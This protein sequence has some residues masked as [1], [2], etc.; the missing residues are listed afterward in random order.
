MTYRNVYTEQLLSLSL[1]PTEI[2]TYETPEGYV[3]VIRD[4]TGYLDNQGGESIAEV[5]CGP[6][7]GNPLIWDCP[8]DTGIRMHWQGRMAI[9][10]GDAFTV[11][12]GGPTTCS[13]DIVVTGFVLTLP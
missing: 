13:A 10:F 5:V 6:T 12:L 4:V 9:P 7:S 2:G 11:A 8:N 1:G 3:A